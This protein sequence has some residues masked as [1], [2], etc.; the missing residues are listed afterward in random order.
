[1]Q[2][3]PRVVQVCG[4]CRIRQY[5]DYPVPMGSRVGA[6]AWILDYLQDTRA[7]AVEAARLLL[8]QWLQSEGRLCAT[9]EGHP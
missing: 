8:V 4:T 9:N 7:T 1:M 2:K 5:H 6:C 3:L